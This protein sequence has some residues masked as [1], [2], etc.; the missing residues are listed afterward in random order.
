MILTPHV[1]G[2]TEEAQVDIGDFVTGKLLGYLQH[3]TTALSVNFPEV[4]L[5]RLEGLTRLLLLHR[6]QPGAMAHVNSALADNGLNIEQQ[7]LSTAGAMGYAVTDV[8]G[9]L[10]PAV[11][12]QLRAMP[13]IVRVDVLPG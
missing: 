3:G 9:P 11:V 4:Q 1:G 12:E 7:Q 8:R 5:T 10:T 6:N 13:E 2:S